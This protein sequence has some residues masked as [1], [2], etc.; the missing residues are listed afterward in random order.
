MPL[1][2][3]ADSQTIIIRVKRTEIRPS[4]EKYDANHYRFYQ[5]KLYDFA[6][7]ASV[8]TVSSFLL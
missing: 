7:E 5:N 3:Q 1:R 8:S 2:S 6:E 4:Q